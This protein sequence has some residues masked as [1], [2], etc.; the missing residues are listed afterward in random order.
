MPL[1]GNPKVY[2]AE[3]KPDLSKPSLEGLSYALRHLPE[4]VGRWKY[5]HTTIENDCGTAG[6]AWGVAR[7]LWPQETGV[8]KAISCDECADWLFGDG[9][10][11]LFFAEGAYR[12]PPA[13]VTSKMVADRIDAY[14]AEAR[15]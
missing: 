15:K 12:Q 1:D 2:E 14:L 5:I 4:T 11:D 10:Y 7:R 13:K 3:T 9:S 6:C 8:H